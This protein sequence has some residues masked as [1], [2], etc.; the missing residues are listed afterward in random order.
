MKFQ[1]YTSDTDTNDATPNS[2]PTE[3]QVEATTDRPPVA[4][5]GATQTRT[6]NKDVALEGEDVEMLTTGDDQGQVVVTEGIQVE[7]A[8][9]ERTRK[10]EEF[11]RRLKGIRDSRQVIGN[12]ET[13]ATLWFASYIKL[14]RFATELVYLVPDVDDN[15][16]RQVVVEQSFACKPGYLIR[17]KVDTSYDDM[18]AMVRTLA[19]A[20]TL[21][22][23]TGRRG[24]GIALLN[25]SEEL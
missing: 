20:K 12:P 15:T 22:L 13:V 5:L 8:Q 3:Q 7:N 9:A 25:H 16:L 4:V 19:T 1:P 14:D 6:L 18:D 17:I 10:R 24:A 2:T 11:V 21:N 23:G